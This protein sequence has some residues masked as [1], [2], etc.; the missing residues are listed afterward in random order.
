[1]KFL[2]L[3]LA[4]EEDPDFWRDSEEGVVDLMMMVVGLT[5]TLEKVVVEESIATYDNCL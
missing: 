3:G 4:G 5:R 1:V 2:V